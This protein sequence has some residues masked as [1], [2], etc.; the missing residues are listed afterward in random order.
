[1]GKIK[2]NCID[3]KQLQTNVQFVLLYDMETV[4]LDSSFL[5]TNHIQVPIK[6]M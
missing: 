1:M 2:H 3:S 4:T 5:L 6:C